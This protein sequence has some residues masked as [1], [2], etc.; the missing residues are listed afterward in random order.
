[1]QSIKMSLASDEALDDRRSRAK[2]TLPPNIVFINMKEKYNEFLMDRFYT[3]SM[4]PNFPLEDELDSLEYMKASLTAV[5]EEDKIMNTDYHFIIMLSLP[6]P[7]DPSS[8]IEFTEDNFK[9]D[10]IGGVIYEYFIQANVG[11]LT[12]LVV[13]HKWRG[14]NVGGILS[15]KCRESLEEHAKS[16]GH[17]AG[18]NAIF[19]ETNSAVKVKESLDVMPPARR[20]EIFYNMGLRLVDFDYVQAPIDKDKKKVNYLLLCCFITPRIPSIKSGNNIQYYLPN[21]LLMNTIFAFWSNSPGRSRRFAEDVDYKRMQDQLKRRERIALLDLPWERPFT[22]VDLYEHFDLELL[23][24]F[25]QDFLLPLYKDDPGELDTLDRWLEYLSPK[26]REANGNDSVIFHL[27]LALKYSED[28]EENSKP[29]IAGGLSFEYYSTNNC[30]FLTYLIAPIGERGER[31]AR[32]LIDRAISELDNDAK[33]GG[34][35]GGCNVI[36]MECAQTISRSP[37]TIQYGIQDIED[38]HPLLESMGW[39]MVDFDY[40]PPPNDDPSIKSQ[41]MF[42]LALITPRIPVLIQE[43]SQYLY[44]PTSTV[45][46]FVSD[47]WD[48]SCSRLEYDYK[49]D[50]EYINMI[51]QLERR[52]RIPLL[53][54]P[55]NKPWSLI[56]LQENA[57]PQLLKQFY[58]ELLE[59]FYSTRNEDLEPIEAWEKKLGVPSEKTELFHILLAV[60]DPSNKKDDIYSVLGGLVFKYLEATNCGFISLSLLQTSNNRELVAKSL[61]ERAVDILDQDAVN[62]GNLAGC[63]AIFLETSDPNL[64]LEDDK[65]GQRTHNQEYSKLDISAQHSMLHRLGWRLVDFNYVGPPA[66]KR[67]KPTVHKSLAIFLTNRI[68]KVS[69]NTEDSYHCLPRTMLESFVQEYWKV[70]CLPHPYDFKKDPQFNT[71]MDLMKRREKIPLLDLPWER[72][73]TLVDLWEDFDAQLLYK[74]YQNFYVKNFPDK[75]QREPLSTWLNLLSVE[76]RDDPSIEDFHVLVAL[77]HPT[78][79]TTKTP[80]SNILGGLMF[81]YYTTNS[82]GL[83]SYISVPSNV[84]SDELMARNLIEE[85]TVNLNENATLRGHIAGCNA[86][87]MEAPPREDAPNK[88]DNGILHRAGW[89]MLNFQYFRPPL[90]MFSSGGTPYLLLA[91]LTPNIP[92]EKDKNGNTQFSMPKEMLRSFIFQHWK[93]SYQRIGKSMFHKDPAFIKMLE[94]LN[95]LDKVTL[96]ELPWVISTESKL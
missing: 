4:L 26:H 72:P 35:L 2:K 63:N 91:L 25:Y 32:A 84:G 58:K 29:I 47:M 55:W 8:D 50:K 88:V 16:R 14:L 59:P 15:E 41:G 62:R 80:S 76:N 83:L 70:M 12:Y 89:R 33:N 53:S 13:N 40:V 38:Q 94:S 1:M 17:L 46:K 92:R 64:L 28:E 36:F 71:M 66:N 68:P 5:E 56:D 96:V 78:S 74:F 39:K 77:Q 11:L 73:W 42:L 48:N 43:D 6:E 67:G 81:T 52:S 34:Q 24:Q 85:A 65:R 9:G 51:N 69:I 82:C 75:A 23:V 95:H 44:L 10:I 90:S 7:Y 31:M 86:I 30:G 87:F 60:K 22:I 3:E 79:S 37:E 54:R 20:H 49:T 57:N 19:L 93:D 27:L 18:C 61:T 21:H 45:K